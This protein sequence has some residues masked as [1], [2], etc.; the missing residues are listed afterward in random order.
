MTVRRIELVAIAAA[1]A[2]IAACGGS[3]DSPSD[4]GDDPSATTA[5]SDATTTTVADEP[6]TETTE[7]TEPSD[8]IDS[9]SEVQPAVVQIVAQG[10]FRDPEVGMVSTAGSGSGFI[11]SD[12]GLV[13][14]NNHVVTGAAT[15]EVFIGGDA[16]NGYNATIVGVSECN[17]LALIQLDVDEPMP[18]LEWSS[19]APSVGTEV[20]T[21]GFPLGDPE[22]TMTRGI[23]AK[24]NAFGDTP[25]AS[26]DS[27]IE[28]DAN[29]QP[30]NSGG[31]LVG[32]DG[33]VVAVNYASGNVTNQSQFFAIEST[34]AQD[35]VDE[36][37]DGDFESLGINGSAVVDE[38]AG[39]AGVWVAGTAPGSPAAVAG[40]LPGDIVT[41]LNGLPIG[42]DGTMKDYCD[43]LRTAGERP[44]SVEVLRFDTQ[45]ILRGEIN[46][47]LPL[48][49]VVSFAEEIVD[50][51]DVADAPTDTTYTATQTLVD[52]TG[53]ITVDVPVEWADVDTAPFVL[54]D[55]SEAPWIGASTSIADLYG[56]S[57]NVPGMFITSF[58]AMPSEDI[59]GSIA[60]FAPAPGECALDEGLSDYDDGAFVG[61]YQLWGDCGGV[62]AAFVILIANATSGQGSVVVGTQLL[63]D[64][65]FDALDTIMATFNYV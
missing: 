39:L 19:E 7:T 55:G 25:W 35:V 30:G 52:D 57:Y 64:A 37:R 29:I 46:G 33:R 34:L 54:D 14:T 62:G 53:T 60:E 21:A 43:V 31:P 36:L 65:D 26:I 45:E 20:Y 23:V 1:M 12:D 3:D 27:T 56:G 16:T 17:D 63:T 28:H 9:F 2:L 44:I 61:Q 15:L 48:E 59:A 22:Y 24:A 11:V 58:P 47:T 50:D 32:V 42:T 40:L 4:A 38:A 10:S 5:A 49:Q 13:V 41:S 6:A 18:F 8:V 51:V